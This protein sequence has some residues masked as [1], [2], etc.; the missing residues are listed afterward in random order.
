M[1]GRPTQQRLLAVA[2][3]AGVAGL[4]G[5]LDTL[6]ALLGNSV[7]R[8][9]AEA[10]TDPHRVRSPDEVS[11]DTTL[12]LRDREVPM[13]HDH[14]KSGGAAEWGGTSKNGIPSIDDPTLAGSDTGN[15]LLA[16]DDPVFGVQ[17]DGDPRAY[18]QQLLV[19]HEIVNDTFADRGGRFPRRFPVRRSGSLGRFRRWTLAL[20]RRN[21]SRRRSNPHPGHSCTARLY[22]WRSVRSSGGSHR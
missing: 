8:A 6:W 16:P 21:R 7:A 17:V 12:P 14:R 18:P 9:D 22:C 1:S 13:A 5:C 11:A 10:G 3:N 4:A 15:T 2:G 19:R 20:S